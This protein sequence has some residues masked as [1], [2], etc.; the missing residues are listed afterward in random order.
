MFIQR[1]IWYLFSN[2]IPTKSRLAAFLV[3]YYLLQLHYEQMN[4]F[5]DFLMNFQNKKLLL[6]LNFWQ[7]IYLK[8]SIALILISS[9]LLK[10]SLLHCHSPPKNWFL[11][12]E[13]GW[14]YLKILLIYFLFSNPYSQWMCNNMKILVAK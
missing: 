12:F 5:C 3:L 2:V 4:I 8:K 6:I 7:C 11:F 13:I 14:L 10:T 1:T 9:L